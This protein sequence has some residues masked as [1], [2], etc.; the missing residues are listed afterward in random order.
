MR[1]KVYW[2][3]MR[4]GYPNGMSWRTDVVDEDTDQKVGYVYAAREPQTEPYRHISLFDGKYKGDFTTH[5]ECDAFAK[6]VEAV[7][8]HM[9]AVG[10]LPAVSNEAA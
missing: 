7:L 10:E 2:V 6:G 1:L 9:T 4:G 5:Q 3:D 8:N